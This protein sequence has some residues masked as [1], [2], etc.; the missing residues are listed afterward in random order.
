[1]A[2]ELKM[3]FLQFKHKILSEQRHIFDADVN[4]FLS[5]LSS[6]FSKREKCLIA[7]ENYY[8]A[9]VGC[10]L[11]PCFQEE[12]YVDD[13]PVPYS[14]KRMRPRPDLARE[15]RVNPKGISYLYMATTEE[16]A[17]AEVRPWLKQEVSLAQFRLKQDLKVIDLT[18]NQISRSD[19]V[20]IR[21]SGIFTSGKITHGE[22]IKLAWY[23]LNEA[24][25]QPITNNE[26]TSAYA[27]TQ[28]I[29]ELIKS[30]GY[31]G[32]MFKSSVAEGKNLVLFD[33]AKVEFIDCCLRELLEVKY[34]FQSIPNQYTDR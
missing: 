10:D 28:I 8:R 1:M 32:L 23:E 29:A 30:K 20:K 9:Q 22:S 7:G 34:K 27:T 13:I 12:V 4:V 21:I 18:S 15:G 17:L 19:A 3:S 26:D 14:E 33:Q 31:D 6:E 5:G 2:Q 11:Q 16:T 25:S 24:F